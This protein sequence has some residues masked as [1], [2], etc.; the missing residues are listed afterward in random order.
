MIAVCIVLVSQSMVKVMP[1]RGRILEWL[2][3]W[4]GAVYPMKGNDFNLNC[5]NINGN[6]ASTVEVNTFLEV[7]IV[8]NC[9]FWEV[10]VPGKH[11]N[12]AAQLNRLH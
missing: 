2:L 3:Y 7:I 10:K 8:F 9:N 6:N 1:A 12:E 4:T 11:T 5:L